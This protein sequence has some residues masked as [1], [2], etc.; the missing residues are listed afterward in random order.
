MSIAAGGDNI[1]PGSSGH[2]ADIQP[3]HIQ[4][5][6]SP[7]KHRKI[8]YI[9]VPFTNPANLTCDGAFHPL[10]L[11]PADL[12][13]TG[14]DR[15][16]LQDDR[17]ECF[18]AKAAESASGEAQRKPHLR[19]TRRNLPPEDRPNTRATAEKS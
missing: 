17:A 14:D 15:P 9:S 16:T 10:R 8:L 1:A 4:P 18:D 19:K 2:Y 5:I 7:Y 11:S 12:R 3:E 6:S 13:S